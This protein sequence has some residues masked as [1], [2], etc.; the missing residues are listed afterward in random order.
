[1]LACGHAMAEVV[2]LDSP[3]DSVMVSSQGTAM[4]PKVSDEACFSGRDFA[5]AVR[6][7]DKYDEKATQ[8]HLRFNHFAPAEI[9]STF[10]TAKDKIN[11]NTEGIFTANS[12]AL[13]NTVKRCADNPATVGFIY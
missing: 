13:L 4:N 11:G 5:G 10:G 3:K 12:P 8:R 6:S 2:T 9:Y 7:R 1:M